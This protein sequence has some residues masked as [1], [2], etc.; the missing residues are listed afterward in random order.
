MTTQQFT[1]ACKPAVRAARNARTAGH[2][3]LG[4]GSAYFLSRMAMAQLVLYLPV[5]ISVVLSWALCMGWYFLVE[6]TL[7]KIILPVIGYQRDGGG[8]KKNEKMM[9]RILTG[10]ALVLAI[11]TACFSLMAS[12]EIADGSTPQVDNSELNATATTVNDG[13]AEEAGRITAQLNEARAQDAH[14]LQ[15]AK[16]EATA[17]LK[18]AERSKGEKMYQLYKD[19]NGWAA[20]QLRTAMN[21]ARN[22][23]DDLIAQ[24]K[25]SARGPGLAA[26]LD[27]RMAGCGQSRDSMMATLSFIGHSNNSRYNNTLARRSWG[28]VILQIFALIVY[29]GSNMIIAVNCD[30]TGE[31]V[32]DDDL[33][34]GRVVG[35]A[36]KQTNTKT[37]KNLADRWKVNF[38]SP[39]PAMA[40]AGGGQ[41]LTQPKR[42]NKSHKQPKSTQP[43]SKAATQKPT[44]N[45]DNKPTQPVP[46]RVSTTQQRPTQQPARPSLDKLLELTQEEKMRYMQQFDSQKL[47]DK[48]YMC[49]LLYDGTQDQNVV[50]VKDYEVNQEG[51]ALLVHA[52]K[53][54]RW[55]MRQIREVVEREYNKN[56]PEL[57][58][59]V[60]IHK[61]NEAILLGMQMRKQALDSWISAGCPQSKDQLAQSRPPNY[62]ARSKG[63]STNDLSK[64]ITD[65][66]K[67]IR[68]RYGRAVQYAREARE[69]REQGNTELAQHKANLSREGFQRADE[70]YHFLMNNGIKPLYNSDTGKVDF[71]NA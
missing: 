2:I 62:L 41:V 29:L 64:E 56:T 34:I 9:G 60:E 23:G 48:G 51:V 17:L 63:T 28:L 21:R 38:S 13:C 42:Q 53:C 8:L 18:R 59:A 6:S 54:K 30:M 11:A 55:E 15:Q 68:T 70:D 47:I 12:P 16:A 27:Q 49:V 67:R 37:A 36:L 33:T 58:K 71:D 52:I 7:H 25:A 4:L 31:K 50:L 40:L 43:P 14:T 19:G 26:M 39:T 35:K 22:Q 24:A 61:D 66:K 3:L 69:A 46:Q 1:E 20:G 65:T 45:I 32:Q 57:G 10:V 5:S 44:Q